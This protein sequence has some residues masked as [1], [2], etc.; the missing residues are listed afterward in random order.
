MI[1]YLKDGNWN[2]GMVAGIGRL[3]SD[4]TDQWKMNRFLNRIMNRWISFSLLS[5]SL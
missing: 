3:A 1:P 5:C 4:L 2:E